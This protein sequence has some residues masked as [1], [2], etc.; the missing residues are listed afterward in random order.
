MMVM[1]KTWE[2]W[3]HLAWHEELLAKQKASQQMQGGGNQQGG[4]KVSESIS[5]K[6]LPPDGQKQMAAQAQQM[7][8]Q[9]PQNPNQPP[10]Q[11]PPGLPAPQNSNQNMPSPFADNLSQTQSAFTR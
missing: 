7:Q 6:D 10:Q 1:P 5:F 8:M 4:N 9:N 2:T 11:Q 3:T